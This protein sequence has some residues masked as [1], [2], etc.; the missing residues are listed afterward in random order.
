MMRDV[1]KDMAL[2]A[3]WDQDA[4]AFAV[5]PSFAERKATLIF[6]PRL[7]RSNADHDQ[8]GVGSVSESCH[9]IARACRIGAMR[10]MTSPC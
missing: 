10:K 8:A 4:N 1:N 9:F 3:T 5:K 2:V 7:I 6:A